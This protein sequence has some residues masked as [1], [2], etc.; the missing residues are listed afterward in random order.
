VNPREALNKILWDK[1]LNVN[2]FDVTF[3]HRGAEKD[4]KTIPYS[5]IVKVGRSWFLYREGEGEFETF[6]PFHRILTIRN[7]CNGD[8]LWLKK[9]YKPR[10]PS[11]LP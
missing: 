11:T 1:K 2:D 7:V 8:I 6:I 9:S 10:Q 3:I 4:E 5:S